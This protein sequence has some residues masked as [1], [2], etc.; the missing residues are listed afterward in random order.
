MSPVPALDENLDVSRCSACTHHYCCRKSSCDK[1]LGRLLYGVEPLKSPVDPGYCNY[2]SRTGCI[3]EWNRR[4]RQ[5]RVFMCTEWVA[6]DARKRGVPVEEAVREH[7]DEIL[8]AAREDSRRAQDTL[9]R[10]SGRPSASLSRLLD[11]V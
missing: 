3:I 8:A 7:Q 5:C 10:L 1:A 4:P 11:P 9:D 6:E 2:M